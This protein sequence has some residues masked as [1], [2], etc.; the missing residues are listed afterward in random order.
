MERLRDFYK[1]TQ[2]NS[3]KNPEK[4][5]SDRVSKLINHINKEISKLEEN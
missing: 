5:S 4:V 2:T 1:E 3:I